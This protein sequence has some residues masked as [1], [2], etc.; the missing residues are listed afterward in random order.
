[1]RADLLVVKDGDANVEALLPEFVCAGLTRTRD[2]DNFV[3]GDRRWR[4]SYENR[5]SGMGRGLTRI[6]R[7]DGAPESARRTTCARGVESRP[8]PSFVAWH[9]HSALCSSRRPRLLAAYSNTFLSALG[10]TEI[11]AR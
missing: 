6:G 11:I 4:H 7:G 5:S 2:D 3:R 8:H 9:A 10:K 1:M